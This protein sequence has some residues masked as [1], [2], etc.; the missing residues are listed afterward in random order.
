[1][2]VTFVIKHSKFRDFQEPSGTLW[3]S[4]KRDKSF[5]NIARW[6]WHQAFVSPQG[7]PWIVTQSLPVAAGGGGFPTQKYT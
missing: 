4:G 2:D 7:D 6:P 3:I 1:M 5:G